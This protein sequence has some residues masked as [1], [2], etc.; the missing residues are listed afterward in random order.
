MLSERRAV[1]T[2]RCHQCVTL[3]LLS[4]CTWNALELEGGVPHKSICWQGG[5][6]NS[7]D[8]QEEWG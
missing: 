5:G 7:L 4:F 1:L 2:C 6:G 8:F 3:V